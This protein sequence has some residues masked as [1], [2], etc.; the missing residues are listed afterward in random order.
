MVK[1]KHKL[2]YIKYYFCDN[3]TCRNKIHFLCK[4]NIMRMN[5]QLNN[6]LKTICYY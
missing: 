6:C 4:K 3:I 5:T 2:K 1:I